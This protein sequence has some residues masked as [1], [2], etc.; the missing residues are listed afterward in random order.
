VLE[1]TIP[2][3]QQL[4]DA[5]AALK[6]AIVSS[7]AGITTEKETAAGEEVKSKTTKRIDVAMNIVTAVLF[8]FLVFPIYRRE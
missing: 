6:D 4:P 8:I 2:G 3:I 5:A 1:E 7:A